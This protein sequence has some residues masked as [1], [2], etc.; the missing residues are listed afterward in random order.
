MRRVILLAA[1][2]AT[3]GL[4]SGCV[5]GDVINTITYAFDIVGVWL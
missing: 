1:L 4:L 5:A 2:T 3:L